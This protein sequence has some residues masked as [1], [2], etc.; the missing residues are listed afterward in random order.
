MEEPRS[1]TGQGGDEAPRRRSTA[2]DTR[3]KSAPGDRPQRTGEASR[4]QRTGDASRR[5]ASRGKR[6]RRRGGVAAAG[7][8]LYVVAVIGVS[9]LLAAVGW[10]CAGDVLALNKAPLSAEVVLPQDFFTSREVT[11]KGEDGAADTTQTVL[12]ADMGKVAELLKEKGFIEYKPVFKLFSAMTK[13]KTKLA[14]GTYQLNTDM[15]YR[16]LIS[17]LGVK[18]G[19]KAEISVTIPEGYS[20]AQ[21]FELLEEKGVAS[22]TALNDMAA[23]HDYKFEFLE[24]IPLGDPKR[25]EGYLFPDTYRFYVNENPL[26]AINKMLVNFSKM[27]SKEQRETLKAEGK[28]LR[29]ILTIASMIEKETDGTDQALIASV[30]YNRLNHPNSGTNGYLQIDATLVYIN[31]GNQPTEADK[32]ID[33][34]YNTYLYPGLPAGPIANPGS[35]AIWA[36]LNPKES[37]YYYYALGTDGRHHYSRTYSEHQAFLNSLPKE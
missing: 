22:V 8:A 11:V 17:A 16:A 27:V 30:I 35:A 10:V 29:E 20:V 37:D 19:S 1:Y 5:G 14:P 28:D 2:G 15:D 9:V 31:G 32:T 25:L 3:R 7:A 36:A 23:N 26:Y 21:I 6:R 4:P 18:S 13:A 12:E 24:G 34:P 33:S